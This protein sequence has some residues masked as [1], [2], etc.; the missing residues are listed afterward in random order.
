MLLLGASTSAGTWAALAVLV[1]LLVVILGAV[2]RLTWRASSWTTST[3]RSIETLGSGLGEAK[4]STAIAANKAVEVADRT[5]QLHVTLEEKMGEAKDSNDRIEAK[6]E[7]VAETVE[8]H[9]KERE[10]ALGRIEDHLAQVT[11]TVDA[12]VISDAT[13]LASIEAKVDENSATFHEHIAAEDA[14]LG[15]VADKLTELT[16]GS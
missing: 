8:A 2:L 5:E 14:V 16:N 1:P 12:H 6:V 11:E 3:D 7:H 13:A 9:K 4:A 15:R 10:A